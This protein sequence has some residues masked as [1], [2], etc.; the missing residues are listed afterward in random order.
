VPSAPTFGC[1]PALSA[2]EQRHSFPGRRLVVNALRIV[3]VAGL[4]LLAASLLG[5]ANDLQLAAGT[6]LISGLG[7]VVL[8]AW[9]NPAWFRQLAGIA[10]LFKL[11]LVALLFSGDAA[12]VP[13]FWIVLVFSVALSHAPG[14][15]RHRRL[16]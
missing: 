7:I 13:L 12:R 4:A 6:M 5:S 14:S 11:G 3:H 10:T 2:T 15:V 16:F 1:V 9:A 8:D